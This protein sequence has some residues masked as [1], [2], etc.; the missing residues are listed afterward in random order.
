[1]G[2]SCFSWGFLCSLA[3]LDAGLS[4]NP[5][6][7]IEALAVSGLLCFRSWEYLIYC[8]WVCLF[9][10]NLFYFIASFPWWQIGNLP[11]CIICFIQWSKNHFKMFPLKKLKNNWA[12]RRNINAFLKVCNGFQFIHEMWCKFWH[13]GIWQCMSDPCYRAPSPEQF[14]HRV[15]LRVAGG[16]WIT[17]LQSLTSWDD[18]W[19]VCFC[20]P[21]AWEGNPLPS[22]LCGVAWTT[23]MWTLR[24]GERRALCRG[25]RSV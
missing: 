14:R 3:H 17:G 11:K 19:T 24:R 18:T 4:S 22:S 1:M 5:L 8:F 25:F 6:Q 12:D 23:V 9:L 21:R 7:I 10:F 13:L 2:K 15:I 20:P 16:E